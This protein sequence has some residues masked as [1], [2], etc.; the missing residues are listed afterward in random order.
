MKYLIGLCVIGCNFILINACKNFLLYIEF[1]LI[2]WS[3][4]LKKS[5]SK[6]LKKILYATRNILRP[7]VFYL[8]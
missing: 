5:S 2:K 7:S 8:V 1:F 4:H 6:M 3:F